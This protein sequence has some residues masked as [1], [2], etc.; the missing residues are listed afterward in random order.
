MFGG[1]L[2]AHPHLPS[3]PGSTG[4][5][6]R[7]KPEILLY[8]NKIRKDNLRFL[9]AAV[10][11]NI[12]VS[13]VPIAIGMLAVT[14]LIFHHSSQQR[15]I[16]L[17][18]SGAFRGV[19]K[20]DYLD[21]LV[22]V[23]LGHSALV[24]LT[25]AISVIWAA[26]QVGF[27][28]AC[29]FDAMFE[30]APRRFVREKLIHILMFLM[31]V[32]LMFLIVGATVARSV[33]NHQ[34]GRSTAPHIIQYPI[35]TVVSLVTAFVLFAVIYLVYPNI[36]HELRL[37]HVWSGA[38][39]AAVLFQFLTFIWPLYVEQL[40][41]YGGILVP[42]LILVLWIY[43]FSLI[44][45]LGGE[46]VAIRAIRDAQKHGKPLGP[47]PDGTVPQHDTLRRAQVHS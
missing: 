4:F 22:T 18:I 41:K 9:T 11:W 45:L 17:F 43:L 37:K 19:L 39:V 25:A 44:L 16:S 28:I 29:A 27:G 2:D 46:V 35:T 36:N 30:V 15:Q 21:K 5:I 24:A 1:R 14:G 13:V 20:P 7:M 12:L 40:S 32:A 47:L 10:A 3:M 8:H 42:L 38:L 23:T 6:T 33:I 31:F 34:I 26:E